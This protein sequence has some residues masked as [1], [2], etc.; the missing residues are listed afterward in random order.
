MHAAAPIRPKAVVRVHG[1]TAPRGRGGN[2]GLG[3]ALMGVLATLIFA[4]SALMLHTVVSSGDA[5]A[6]ELVRSNPGGAAGSV[7]RW[8][9]KWRA[10]KGS[11]VMSDAATADAHASST[12]SSAGGP[13]L[14]PAAQLL[15]EMRRR[16]LAAASGPSR[17][18]GSEAVDFVDNYVARRRAALQAI[19]FVRSMSERLAGDIAGD[20]FLADLAAGVASPDAPHE[21]DVMLPEPST[22]TCTMQG[23]SFDICKY[24]NVCVDAPGPFAV[25]R[26]DLPGSLLFIKSEAAAAGG[27]EPVESSPSGSAAAAGPTLGGASLHDR[28]ARHRRRD[29]PL[30]EGV[31]AWNVTGLVAG[32]QWDSFDV[33]SWRGRQVLFSRLCASVLLCGRRGARTQKGTR[34]FI[35]HV[36]RRRLYLVVL[37]FTLTWRTRRSA[38][39]LALCRGPFG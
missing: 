16:I 32:R 9:Q 21:E 12:T 29:R 35:T 36:G 13:P 31:P 11:G 5:H 28:I 8:M 4:A 2:G 14:P 18:V 3:Y 27:A 23:D 15:G 17:G 19:R 24:E 6:R 25:E 37:R 33:V 22:A 30:G 38:S 34:S 39:P 1:G 20:V 7:S 10:T 26:W